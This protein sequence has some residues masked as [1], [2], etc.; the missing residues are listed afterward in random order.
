MADP[1]KKFS[2]QMDADLLK[3][4]RSYATAE[5]KDLQ[6]VL[7][8]A[9]EMFLMNMGVRRK[10]PDFTELAHK[11]SADMPDTLSYLAK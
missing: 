5:R 10:R 2:S 1:R 9:G 8:E 4:L 3:D 11:V 6:E 7:E